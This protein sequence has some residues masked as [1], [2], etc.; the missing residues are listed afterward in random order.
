MYI[1]IGKPQDV[2]LNDVWNLNLKK[3]W[4]LFKKSFEDN[5]SED[6]LEI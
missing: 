1:Y 6:N 2:Y 3:F 4:P 5:K